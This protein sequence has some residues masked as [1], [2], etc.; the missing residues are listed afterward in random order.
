MPLCAEKSSI[1]VVALSFPLLC[2]ALKKIRSSFC[3][4]KKRSFVSML[5]LRCYISD[6]WAE[7]KDGQGNI[8]A[9]KKVTRLS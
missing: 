4:C 5:L 6:E 9:H 8:H 7:K 3:T 1:H 2:G